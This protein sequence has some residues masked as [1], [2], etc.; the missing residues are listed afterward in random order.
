MDLSK[1]QQDMAN[2]ASK[3]LQ[4]GFTDLH[5]DIASPAMYPSMSKI[6]Q[7]IDLMIW[8]T[9]DMSEAS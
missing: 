3:T 1:A 2:L 7:G 9:F 5:G 8:L 4:L 6:I